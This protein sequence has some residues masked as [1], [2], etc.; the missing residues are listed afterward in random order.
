MTARKYN[1]VSHILEFEL[2]PQVNPHRKIGSAK[3]S[4]KKTRKDYTFSLK[5]D[6]SQKG[7]FEQPLNMFSRKLAM[8]L[9]KGIWDFYEEIILL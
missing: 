4:Q 3:V 8:V 1:S 5:L 2:I 7:N 6:K 9:A